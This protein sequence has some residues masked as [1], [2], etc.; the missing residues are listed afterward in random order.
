VTLFVLASAK[1]SPGVTTLAQLL[2]LALAAAGE[3]QE[4]R[5][6]PVLLVEADPAGGDLA[7]RRGLPGTPG[8][9]TLALRARRSLLPADVLS[10]CQTIVGGVETLVGVAGREQSAALEPVL[11]RIVEALSGLP[12]LVVVDA[13]RVDVSSPLSLALLGA[14][15]PPSVVTRATT[16]ALL[17]TRSACES[18][19]KRGIAPELVLVGRGRHHSKDVADAV[20]AGILGTVVD[21]PRDAARS[22]GGL[23]DPRCLLSRSVQVLAGV[24]Q[25]RLAGRATAS[26]VALP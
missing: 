13:G 22:Y 4:A 20:G 2:A 26:A 12:H 21:S 3:R 16:E 25:G 19:R 7:A 6:R 1:G 5:Q 18:L 11:G 15:Q 24:I 8:L 14:G 23:P 17:H 9:A 10:H